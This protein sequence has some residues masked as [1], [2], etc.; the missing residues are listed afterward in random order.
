[1]FFHFYKNLLH[2]FLLF[3]KEVL[4]F[5][6][7]SIFRKCL[8]LKLSFNLVFFSF[9]LW[10][11]EITYYFFS[12]F[13]DLFFFSNLINFDFF[14]LPHYLLFIFFSFAQ[15]YVG[16][17]IFSFY[18]FVLFSFGIFLL[19]Y[20]FFISFIFIFISLA[21]NFYDFIFKSKIA[22]LLF[23]SRDFLSVEDE[24]LWVCSNMF[25]FDNQVIESQDF[26]ISLTSDDIEVFSTI[27][28]MF[29]DIPFKSSEYYIFSN[30]L[31][32]FKSDFLKH[33]DRKRDNGIN[34]LEELYSK[35]RLSKQLSS[36][37][38][39]FFSLFLVKDSSSYS[40]DNNSL[41]Q[42]L[43]SKIFYPSFFNFL[44]HLINFYIPSLK[45]TK[46]DKLKEEKL[47]Y[48]YRKFKKKFSM[49]KSFTFRKF[50]FANSV[51]PL[52][53]SAKISIQQKIDNKS[54]FINIKN[55]KTF[56]E[57]YFSIKNSL[58][59]FS[60]SQKFSISAFSYFRK[61]TL[62]NELN[63]KVKLQRFR[64]FFW[65]SFPF[66]IL[67][68]YNLFL[69]SFLNSKLLVVFYSFYK[70]LLSKFIYILFWLF[71]DDFP[72]DINPLFEYKV[73]NYNPNV[74]LKKLNDTFLN[75]IK[76]KNPDFQFVSKIF[77]S[78]FNFDG[79][80]IN[81]DESNESNDLKIKKSTDFN[82]IVK[83][84]SLVDDLQIILDSN[85]QISSRTRK[86]LQKL[87]KE[88][89]EERENRFLNFLNRK[90]GT[91][92]KQKLVFG[93][94]Y[95]FSNKYNSKSL[96][97]HPKIE[98]LDFYKLLEYFYFVLTND[99]NFYENAQ[100]NAKVE[101]LRQKYGQAIVNDL[102]DSKDHKQA[103]KVSVQL[104]VVDHISKDQIIESSD[105]FQSSNVT[106]TKVN[107]NFLEKEFDIKNSFKSKRKTVSRLS[108]DNFVDD[109]ILSYKYRFRK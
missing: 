8:D 81:L 93:N 68:I 25:Y 97:Y 103:K 87:K 15:V 66:Y 30:Q 62:Y 12:L 48:Q 72:S 14:F 2:F 53:L 43:N 32:L 64:R 89:S 63:N 1:M 51:N 26:K 83:P 77:Q 7:L 85:S 9:P 49:R 20:L 52:S 3:I 61:Q 86:A 105:S 16:N 31:F 22:G 60:S 39:N 65:I 70:S 74:K 69:L 40:K 94:K 79:Y 24:D 78:F 23:L 90:P 33:L 92:E 99:I 67:E 42:L 75:F 34:I 27:I 84:D 56:L 107:D 4:K 38:S 6:N 106:D 102:L 54:N 45:S 104:H 21:M 95:Y 29:F 44:L 19:S 41:K 100:F 13:Y 108:V 91:V 109:L 11:D 50:N 28:R 37:L 71:G 59:F 57:Q 82:F 18:F 46:L 76:T 5:F 98:L 55:R 35:A 73:S 88:I 96:F 47:K 80:S 58:E 36:K 101:I 17:F 10:S